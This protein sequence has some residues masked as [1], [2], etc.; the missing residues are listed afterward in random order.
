MRSANFARIEFC[1]LRV[2][3]V[4]PSTPLGGCAELPGMVAYLRA[5]VDAKGRAEE[6]LARATDALERPEGVQVSERE[7][8]RLRALMARADALGN[9]CVAVEDWSATEAS[10]RT[11]VLEALTPLRE[12]AHR[13]FMAY[14]REVRLPEPGN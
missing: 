13:D 4:L 14:R 9:A 7:G 10:Y 2:A 11:W 6:E 12:E 5:L 3:G 1:E 8:E